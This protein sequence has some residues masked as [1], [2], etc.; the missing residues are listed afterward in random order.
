M[1]NQT[2]KHNNKPKIYCI[3]SA[4]YLPHMGGVERYTSYLA[5]GLMAEGNQVLVITTNPGDLPDYQKLDGVPVLRLPAISLMDGRFPIPRPGRKFLRLHRRLAG[6]HPDVVL[7]NTRFYFHSLYGILWGRSQNARTLVLDHGSG[8]LYLPNPVLNQLGQWYEHGITVLEKHFCREYY[9]VSLAS[10]KWLRHFHIHARGILPNAI[11]L[12]A[13][14]QRLAQPKT[15]FR[16]KY[17][18]PSDA[19]VIVYTGRLIPEKGLLPLRDG[20]LRFQKKYSNAYLLLAGD[21]PLEN[22]LNAYQ[23]SHILLTGRLQQDAIIDLLHA[24][25][26]F[27]L[28]SVSEGFSTSILEAAACRNYLIITASACPREL[29]KDPAYAAILPD[30]KPD[31]IC[32]ALYAAAKDPNGRTKATEKTWKQLKTHFTWEKTL[33]KFH[34]YLEHSAP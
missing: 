14:T 33:E 3:F 26:I 4:Q 22:S 29:L 27:C 34:D 10:V 19:L 9:G 12:S 8:H 16:K 15:D 6:I 11:D 24:S 21:G 28:P 5:K 7:V 18:I 23:S 17:Q 30:A 20:F 13:I 31:T 1:R 25:D 32:Q 2:Q